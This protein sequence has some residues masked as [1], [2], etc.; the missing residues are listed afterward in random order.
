[1]QPTARIPPDQHNRTDIIRYH[2]ILHVSFVHRPDQ[3][4]LLTTRVGADLDTIISRRTY[5]Y[6]SAMCVL[7]IQGPVPLTL[8]RVQCAV[9]IATA[10]FLC[11]R[12]LGRRGGSQLRASIAYREWAL[13]CTV[14]QC[15]L[16]NCEPPSIHWLD[17]MDVPVLRGYRSSVCRLYCSHCW[18][19][20]MGF[21]GQR[22]PSSGAD[23]LS[24]LASRVS[25]G[26]ELS[27]SREFTA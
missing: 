21:G 8:T 14:P 11:I 20:S 3:H 10:R 13:D 9:Y 5:G 15:R 23:T 17:E 12:S 19:R 1:M 22:S 18:H 16:P 27:I 7:P 2:H 26:T 4:A 24:A 6:S 25:N